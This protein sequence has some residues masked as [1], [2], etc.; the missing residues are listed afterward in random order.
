ML[1]IIPTAIKVD[2][3][4]AWIHVSHVK[5]ATPVKEKD[6]IQIWTVQTT[7]LNVKSQEN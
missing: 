7:E 5:K 4:A 1:L 3:I 6:N 2:G